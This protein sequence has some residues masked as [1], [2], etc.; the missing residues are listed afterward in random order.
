MLHPK[1]LAVDVGTGERL[2]SAG[3]HGS[4]IAQIDKLWLRAPSYPSD[5]VERDT[6]VAALFELLLSLVIAS[7]P[8]EVLLTAEGCGERLS[9]DGMPN[10]SLSALVRV[11]RRDKWTFGFKI[12][13]LGRFSHTASVTG[14]DP[15]DLVGT[16]PEKGDYQ[17]ETS[18]RV[19]STSERKLEARE[20]KVRLEEVESWD[21]AEG[22]KASTT[23]TGKG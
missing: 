9:E 7:K 2:G 14:K 23:R 8:R 4:A 22:R 10:G 19:L 21:G 16:P 20:G 5:L 13:P 3:D 18:W 15:R 6:S 12:P 1:L 11:H 17:R